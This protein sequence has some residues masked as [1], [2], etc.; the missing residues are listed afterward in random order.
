MI[1][2]AYDSPIFRF[3]AVGPLVVAFYK[4]A[5]TKAQLQELDAFQT[6]L[7]TQHP[8]IMSLT[9]MGQVAA[10]TR[11]D[12]DARAFTGEL[13]TKYEKTNVGSAMVVK[14][15]GLGA[16]VVRSFLSAWFL[17][18][19]T[20]LRAKV[21]K[22]VDEGLGWLQSLPEPNP[23]RQTSVTAAEIDAFCDAP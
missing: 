22:T 17:M 4:G 21:F 19:Q 2:R 20:E 8:R 6:R 3:G 7:L 15:T 14:S 1:E 18:R 13:A 10:T 23:I 16:V 11:M 9:I 12:E 5:T